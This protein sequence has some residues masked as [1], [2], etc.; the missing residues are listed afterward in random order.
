M[1][2]FGVSGKAPRA[3]TAPRGG[4]RD[5]RTAVSLAG[6]GR[7][8]PTTGSSWATDGS[9]GGTA[10]VRIF[11]RAPG[12]RRL[13]ASSTPSTV[14][15]GRVPVGPR[16]HAP[17][18]PRP[19]RRR[20]PRA[21]VGAGDAPREPPPEHGCGRR[22]LA[23]RR[24]VARPRPLAVDHHRRP[25]RVRGFPLRQGPTG[26]VP[27]HAAN[28]DARVSCRIPCR[29]RHFACR[30]TWRTLTSVLESAVTFRPGVAAEAPRGR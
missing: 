12:A 8:T 27:N 14:T 3:G 15:P 24:G 30:R 21:A 13:E 11:R 7:P 23:G 6:C 26:T 29:A 22:Q 18:L 16:Q 2:R 28:S 20:Q 1:R 17:R 19:H 4:D 5:P 10:A 25:V 9:E